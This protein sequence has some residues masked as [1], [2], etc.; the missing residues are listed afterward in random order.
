[1]INVDTHSWCNHDQSHSVYNFN[2]TNQENFDCHLLN[3]PLINK[4]MSYT[5]SWVTWFASFH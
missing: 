4:L 5:K 1:M 2:F 3:H